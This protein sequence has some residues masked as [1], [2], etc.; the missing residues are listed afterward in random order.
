M[1]E[2]T[3]DGLWL[4]TPVVVIGVM[5][6]VLLATI[7]SDVKNNS[8]NSAR[9]EGARE[10]VAARDKADVANGLAQ[11]AI[12]PKTG[13]VELQRWDPR[14]RWAEGEMRP[15]RFPES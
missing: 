4:A 11:W 9:A 10:A 2:L 6:V 7:Y 15:L 13:K 5:V 1:I 3:N 12:N 14:T 8:I